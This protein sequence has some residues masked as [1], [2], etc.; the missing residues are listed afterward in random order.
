[1]DIILAGSI[2]YDYLMKFPGR[3]ADH[4]LP[5]K[6]NSISLSFLVDSMVRLRGGIAPN[7]A[8]NL[9]LLGGTSRLLATVG[10]DFEDYRLWLHSHRIDTSLVRVVPGV[11]TASFFANTDREN[12]QISSFYP[13]AMTFASELSLYDLEGKDPDLVVISP[14]EPLAMRRC[15]DECQELFIPYFYDPSQQIIRMDGE[16]MRKGVEGAKGLFVNDYEYSLIQ[17]ATGMSPKNI[18]DHVGFLVV[19]LGEKGTTIYTGDEM[20][21]IPAVLP[22]KIA[23][24]TGVGDAFRGGFLYGFS[25]GWDLSFC[26]HIGV[27]SA[28]YC[29]E[30]IGPQG[31]YYTKQDYVTR[32]RENFEDGGLLDELLQMEKK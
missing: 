5:E 25:R 17:K 14:N 31:Q 4:I 19:T 20:L 21:E 29:L 6:L 12:N 16:D 7:I 9:S 11:N 24:P 1:M 8:Y 22:T 2:A 10:E 18:L 3:F 27:L 15:V 32:F 13:G 28:T 23:D 26:G 30:S